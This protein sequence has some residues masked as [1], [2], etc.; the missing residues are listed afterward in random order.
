MPLQ[1]SV[2]MAEKIAVKMALFLPN[3]HDFT[4]VGIVDAHASVA[5]EGFHIIAKLVQFKL[6]SIDDLALDGEISFL[7]NRVAQFGEGRVKAY[8]S[9]FV[10]FAA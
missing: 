9:E 10:A 6:M 4:D 1:I 7:K 2:I 3:V 8:R 5:I